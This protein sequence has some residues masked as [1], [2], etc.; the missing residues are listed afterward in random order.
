MCRVSDNVVV[1][2]FRGSYYLW[3]L[4]TV[5]SWRQCL[6][7]WVI[8]RFRVFVVVVV[9]VFVFVRCV[10]GRIV[11]AVAGN[12]GFAFLWLVGV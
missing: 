4:S 7:V 10:F 11:F 5:S 9:F 12:A 3:W 1:P 8:C 6:R 2:I